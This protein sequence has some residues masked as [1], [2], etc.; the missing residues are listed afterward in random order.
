MLCP[1]RVQLMFKF[2]YFCNIWQW[3]VCGKSCWVYYCIYWRSLWCQHVDNN[4]K[5]K[6]PQSYVCLAKAMWHNT[7]ICQ[8]LDWI[9]VAFRLVLIQN[10][11]GNGLHITWVCGGHSVIFS[12]YLLTKQKTMDALFFFSRI[13]CSIYFDC[14][15]WILNF[16]RNCF[17]HNIAHYANTLNFAS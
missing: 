15:P 17:G 14:E 11:V 8:T 3:W 5:H 12:V 2:F 9:L 13:P 6:T 16:F 4:S 1:P 10:Y 7:A